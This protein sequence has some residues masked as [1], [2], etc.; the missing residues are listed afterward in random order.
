MTFIESHPR[1]ITENVIK[2]IGRE[3]MLVTSGSKDSYNMM[4]ASWGGLGILWYKP[5][6]FIFIRPSRYTFQFLEKNNHFS[7][8][9]F[10]SD[11]KD[12]LNL[13]GSKSG[14]E[15]NKMKEVDLTPIEDQNAV[16]FEESR[17]VL[18]CKK[19]YMHDITNKNFL[20]AIREDIYKDNDFHRMYICEILK[21][22]VKEEV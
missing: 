12:I 9:F 15:I 2:L 14:R 3:W 11:Y 13:C 16:Y 5:V 6:C 19:L 8:G 4:T 18:I 10:T 17:M 1:E 20:S 22:L 7:I 21:C